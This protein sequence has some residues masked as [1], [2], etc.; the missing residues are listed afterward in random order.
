MLT[1]SDTAEV[2][3]I[4]D[5][6]QDLAR[7]AAASSGLTGIAVGSSVAEV[8][9][10]SGAQALVNV[11][12]PRAHLPVT[13][14]ALFAGLPGAQREAPRTHRR[15]GARHGRRVGGIRAAADDQ[16]EPPLLRLARGL[17]RGRRRGGPPGSAHDRLREGGPLPRLPRDHAAPAAGRHGDP[18]VRRGALRAASRSCLRLVRD[19]QPG[20]ELVRRRLDRERRVRVRGRHPLPL[21]RVMDDQRVGHLL[22]RG[23]A[24]ERVTGRRD[25]GRRAVRGRGT[26][27]S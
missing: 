7:S 12:V 24:G 6:D 15:G 8:A 9:A 22:E 1:A 17:P 10:R 18:R 19:L 3:G 20:L 21:H 23:L 26:R 27:G 2:V 4:V 13:V 11:T 5:L 14:E 25:L 16:P